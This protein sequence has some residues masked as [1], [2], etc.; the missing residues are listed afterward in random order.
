MTTEIF[1]SLYTSTWEIFLEIAKKPQKIR[2][3]TTLC[4]SHKLLPVGLLDVRHYILGN[5]NPFELLMKVFS[6]K[7]EKFRR[8]EIHFTHVYEFILVHKIHVFSFYYECPN[9]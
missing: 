1:H 5:M 2:L 9:T 4:R 8:W 7:V 6:R 3:L